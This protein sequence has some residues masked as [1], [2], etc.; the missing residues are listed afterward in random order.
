MTFDVLYALEY[1]EPGE[2]SKAAF[3]IAP[4]P[5]YVADV[6]NFHDA[7]RLYLDA[8]PFRSAAEE[9]LHTLPGSHRRIRHR[10]PNGQK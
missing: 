3:A 4:L 6:I 8:E 10:L 1:A 9:R 7:I 5:R 2:Y